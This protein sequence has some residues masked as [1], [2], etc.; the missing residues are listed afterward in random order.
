MCNTLGANHV[1]HIGCKSCA[2]HWVQIMCNTLGANHVQH[3]GCKSC[4]TH[5]VQFMCNTLGA[6]HVQHI[7]C[8][9]CA[10]HWV[11]IMCNTLGANHVQ[12][13]GC[14]SCAIYWGKSCATHHMPRGTKGQLSCW[15]WQRLNRIYF[16]FNLLAET[17]NWWRRGGNWSTQRK[18]L[19][20][21]FR[22][23]RILK[24][25]PETSSPKWDSNRHSNIG[26]RWGSRRVN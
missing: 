7:G 5:W 18:S 14:K 6:N 23:C 16:S 3:I 21:S 8:K 9:S 25:K 12:H 4:A 10:T 1:Q 19:M 26:D 22:Q 17:I 2:T 11:Q 13:I 15:V 20:M 24:V